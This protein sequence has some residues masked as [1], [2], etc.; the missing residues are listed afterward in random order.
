MTNLLLFESF[1]PTE[2]SY[3]NLIKLDA[4]PSTNDYLK[5]LHKEGRAFDGNL[6]WAKDQTSGRGQRENK[7]ES[8]SENSLTFSVYRDFSETKGISPFLISAAVSLAIIETLQE[9]QIPN[10]AVKWPNDILSC[11]LKTGGILIENFFS[12]GRLKASV[13]GIGLNVSQDVFHHVPLATSLKQVSGKQWKA[14]ELLEALTPFLENALY[15]LDFQDQKA[16]LGQY[17][18]ILWKRNMVSS[19][20]ED[21]KIIKAKLMGV[22]PQGKLLL[23]LKDRR[24]VEK[25]T[26]QIRMLYKTTDH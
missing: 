2:M 6:V 5:K 12:E 3:F 18:N 22:N 23:E 26:Q 19:F 4:I 11:N 25:D 15:N 16:L 24:V 9:L 1:I 21:G 20:L 10:L 7:W 17:Q 8:D 14:D 13:I